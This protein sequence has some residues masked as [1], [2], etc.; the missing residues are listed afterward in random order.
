MFS[1][2][3]KPLYEP[4]NTHCRLYFITLIIYIVCVNL[5]RGPCTTG[6]PFWFGTSPT[7]CTQKYL[8][9]TPCIS[10]EFQRAVQVWHTLYSCCTGLEIT[11]EARFWLVV[12]LWCL[13]QGSSWPNP[14]TYR[15][16]QPCDE[17]WVEDCGCTGN[18]K[19]WKIKK[20]LRWKHV[21]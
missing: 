19:I 12:F 8:L 21:L 2:L 17:P 10:V 4:W 16:V 20:H 7:A 15:N 3:S 9:K 11:S 14:H 1:L 13:R 6:G 18:C 5:T